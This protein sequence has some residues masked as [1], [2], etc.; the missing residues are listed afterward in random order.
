MENNGKNNGKRW[1]V[2]ALPIISAFF[3][4]IGTVY[5]IG[6]RTNKI[7][8]V[9]DWKKETAPMIEKMNGEGTTSFKIF[10]EEYLRRQVRQ[11]AEAEQL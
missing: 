10:H 8:E 11:E 6:Q 9:V 2:Y 4:V 1:L 3:A 7:V 5:V